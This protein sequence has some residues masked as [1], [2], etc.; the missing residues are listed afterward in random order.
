MNKKVFISMLTLCIVFLAGL[1]VAKIFFPQEF[2]MSIQNEKIVAIGQFIDS[3]EWLY[4]I[5]MAIPPYLTYY[6]YCCACSHRLTLKWQE[7]LMIFG[8][9]VLSRLVNFYDA[10]LATAL[11]VTSFVFLP[12]LMK[13]NLKTSA[14]VYTIHGFAQVLSLSIRNLPMYLVNVNYLTSLFLT[15][16]CYLWLALCFIIFNYKEKEE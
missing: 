12:A 11:S 7:H 3:H 14:I 2:M 4:Y 13:G 16:E 8:V 10:N 6:L 1:Y 15:L 5:C 9:V